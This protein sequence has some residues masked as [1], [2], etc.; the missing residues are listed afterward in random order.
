MKIYEYVVRIKDEATDKLKRLANSGSSI[1]NTFSRL[2]NTVTNTGRTFSRFF[3]NVAS[4]FSNMG[5]LVTTF[6]RNLRSVGGAS[7]IRQMFSPLN[8]AVANTGRNF[9]RFFG[10]V[11]SSF[12]GIGS[13]V[14]SFSRNL[15][16]VGGDIM[17]LLG[18]NSALV[19]MLG[20][21]ALVAT[22]A[23]TGRQAVLLAADL[24]QTTVGFEVMLGSA[25]KAN[26]M[27]KEIRQM[28][29]ITPFESVDLFKSAEMQLG[30]G[31]DEKRIMTNLN[32][33][34]DV[35][36]GNADKLRLITLAYSQI[37]AAGRLMGQ[38]LLQ[39]INAG[40]N[41][42]QEISKKTGKS[43]AVL[44][45]EM[46]DGKISADMV[47]QAFEA[48][49]GPGGRFFG[50]MERQSKTFLGLLSTLRDEWSE[51]LTMVGEKLLPNA[52]DGIKGL[53]SVLN[54]LTTRVDFTP[55]VMAFQDTRDAVR[56]LW[57]LFKELIALMGISTSQVDVL[58]MVFNTLAFSMRNGFL[59]LRIL[60]T[61]IKVWIEAIGT[62]IDVTKG[63]ALIL[64]GLHSKNFGLIK[65][66]WEDASK[67]LRE[68][69]G[70]VK[71]DIE[72]FAKREYE[73]YKAIFTTEAKPADAMS[74]LS[75][76]ASAKKGQS[77]DGTVQKGID[78]ITGGG[79]Q[80]INV[81]I[82]IKELT[83][84]GNLEV[85]QLREGVRQMEDQ[86]VEAL[87]R[88]VNSANYATSQ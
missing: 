83:G 32:M 17:N 1:R 19:R 42:L 59:P 37:Q 56:D 38:D 16:G 26:K 52:I 43:M 64:Q 22:M 46:E 60:I 81:T 15:K 25:E 66:G 79:K 69:F 14:M 45:K 74:A 3:G 72:D 55:I 86:V 36:R 65:I 13:G 62:A 29:K 23:L 35:A 71:K 31:I 5:S 84:I 78:N 12:S 21:A 54:D 82:N 58:Q 76:N 8:N 33:L 51:M 70:T 73:G 34:G 53:R 39:L 87:L 68:G 80:A 24:E 75:N 41:P 9:N 47:T 61:G 77:S 49:T 57:G 50:M 85:K 28:A 18:L 88:A 30:F 44:K 48:A 20:P 10:N 2:S 7:T 11:K 63:F 4:S 40:F 27:I 6:G 67:S